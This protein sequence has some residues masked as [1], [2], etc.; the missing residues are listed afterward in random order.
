MAA[1]QGGSSI[2][3]RLARD[4]AVYTPHIRMRRRGGPRFSAR[5]RRLVN[6]KVGDRRCGARTTRT[7]F[8]AGITICAAEQSFWHPEQRG[9]AQSEAPDS[10]F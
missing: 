1:G 4:G 5:E 8:L 3:V 9:T 6:G 7:P 2:R 10:S